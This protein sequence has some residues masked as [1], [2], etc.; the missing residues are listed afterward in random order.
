MKDN[1]QILKLNIQANMLRIDQ[2][3]STEG[4]ENM[5]LEEG[6][7]SVNKD[8]TELRQ[9]MKLLR[10]DTLKLERVLKCT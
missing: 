7:Y 10:K 2:L 4:V 3:L 9:R 6:W 8:N 1:F 5:Y